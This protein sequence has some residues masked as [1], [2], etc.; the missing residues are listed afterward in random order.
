V[1]NIVIRD[2]HDLQPK[3]AQDC[4]AFGVCIG[5]TVVDRTIDFDDQTGPMAVEI[6]DEL[7]G[8]LLPAKV[9]SLKPVCSQFLPEDRL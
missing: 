3:T 8:D 4:V 1:L 7:A 6:D 5:L 2:A 9:H